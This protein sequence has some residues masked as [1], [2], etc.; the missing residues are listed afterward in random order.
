MQMTLRK[1]TVDK[2]VRYNSKNEQTQS[3]SKERDIK[4]N[5][6]LSRKQNV[7]KADS[8][9]SAR[10]NLSRSNKKTPKAFTAEGFKVF[11]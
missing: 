2:S 11:K 10:K 4:P 5:R 7:S 3:I 6:T 9:R 1:I 8:A